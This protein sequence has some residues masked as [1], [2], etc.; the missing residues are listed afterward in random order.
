M[1]ELLLSSAS[2]NSRTSQF[3][4]LWQWG[5]AQKAVGQHG[6]ESWPKLAKGKFHSIPFHRTPFPGYHLGKLAGGCQLLYYA[7]LVSVS[8]IPLSLQLLLYFV[9]FQSS[10]CSHPTDVT[11]PSPCTLCAAGIWHW[12]CPTPPLSPL[13]RKPALPL[14]SF[15][16]SLF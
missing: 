6:Q 12:H 16:L 13:H 11:L 15:T 9:L 4:R 8:V 3:P 14:G 1:F 5:R 2:P 7:P 10:N